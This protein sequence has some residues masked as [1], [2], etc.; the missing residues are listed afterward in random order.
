MSNPILGGGGFHHVCMKTRNWDRTMRFYQE[1]LGCTAK[2][3][4]RAAPQRA[5]AAAEE[6]PR[7]Q[8]V[9]DDSNRPAAPCLNAQPLA[10]AARRQV[11]F[12]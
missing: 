6:E 1:T 9:W 5:A 8:A 3:A 10:R 11:L 7:A 12:E 2:I 4:W